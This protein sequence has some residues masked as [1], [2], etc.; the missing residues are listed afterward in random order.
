MNRMLIIAAVSVMCLATVAGIAWEEESDGAGLLN[1]NHEQDG[2]AY[3]TTGSDGAMVMGVIDHSLEK[4]NIPDSIIVNQKVYR[5]TSI[6]TSA[7]EDMTSLVEVVIG[8]NVRDIAGSAFADC[9]SLEFVS[10]P[11]NLEIIMGGAFAGCTS[12]KHI[13]LPDSLKTIRSDAFARSGLT[14]DFTLPE[15]L[16]RLDEDVFQQCT[17]LTGTVNIP[18]TLNGGEFDHCSFS[19][20][21]FSEGASG[22]FS[23]DRMENLEEVIFPAGESGITGLSFNGC[24][25]LKTI[26]LPEGITSIDDEAFYGCTSLTSMRIPDSVTEIG[27]RAFFECFGLADVE[28][29]SGLKTIGDSAFYHC[30][31]LESL[32][33]PEGLTTLGDDS[34]EFCENVTFVD[35]PSTL[36]EMST[37]G[38]IFFKD[39]LGD[40]LMRNAKDLAGKQFTMVDGYFVQSDVFSLIVESSGH[41]TVTGT[42]MYPP[43]T[44]VTIVAVPDDGWNFVEWSDGVKDPIRTI[45]MDSD[46]TLWAYFEN[47][48]ELSHS[49]MKVLYVVIAVIIVVGMVSLAYVLWRHEHKN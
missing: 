15:G 18:S 7:F 21:V 28:F 13:E 46:I 12:L 30:T 44:E 29:G 25:A 36:T 24:T 23:F 3:L 39:R 22:R 14:G 17:N 45:T 27:E 32:V 48:D 33:F 9:T 31:A 19:K 38:N 42:G 47:P 43:N 35:F 37:F 41:G 34:F 5:V 26:E 1:H 8:N 40:D 49:D 16:E 6:N 2:I 10:L 11:D 20:V 4:V